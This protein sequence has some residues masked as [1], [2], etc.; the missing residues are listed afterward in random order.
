MKARLGKVIF[1]M[2]PLHP[3]WQKPVARFPGLISPWKP[4]SFVCLSLVQH[5]Q[6]QNC[7]KID[8]G[9]DQQASGGDVRSAEGKTRGV[10]RKEKTNCKNS[11]R[12]AET[13]FACGRW[14]H[15]EG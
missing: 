6:S 15:S 9:S 5:H 3:V 2:F 11:E 7:R 1:D 4:D 14:N 10:V 13:Q 12:I 8:D